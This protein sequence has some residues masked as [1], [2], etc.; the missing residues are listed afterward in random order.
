MNRAQRRQ[1]ARKNGWKGSK[2]KRGVTFADALAAGVKAHEQEQ[3]AAYVAK[4]QEAAR[5]TRDMGLVIP[6]Q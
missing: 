3:H 5:R 6:G 1:L 2:A 4:I